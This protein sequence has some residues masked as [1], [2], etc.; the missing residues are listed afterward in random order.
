MV[1][2]EECGDGWLVELWR[3]LPLKSGDG[4]YRRVWR[5]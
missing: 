2:T 1:G 4:W 5:W 3:W